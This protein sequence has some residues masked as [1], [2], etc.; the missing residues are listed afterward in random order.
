MIV[1]NR[2]VF[3]SRSILKTVAAAI[4]G[5]LSCSLVS[6]HPSWGIVVSSNGIVYF[7]DL[8]TI[9]RID[10][11]GKLSVVRAGVSGRHTHE[12]AIDEQDDIYGPDL[13][14]EPAT[15]KWITAIWKMTPDGKF[16]YLQPPSNQAPPGMSIWLDRGGNM[17][18]VD[19]NNHTKTKTVLLKRTPK[20]V[21]STLAGGVYGHMDGKG[22]AAKLSTVG[23]MVFGADGNLYLSDGEYV[24]RV[25]MD[26]AVTTIAKD[27]LSRTAED[28][29]ALFG[30]SYGSL[31]GL[32]TEPGGNVYVADAGNR[33]LLKISRDG[34][35]T[36][37]YRCDPPFF[38]NGVFATSAG[39]VYV[40]EF[41]FVPPGTWGGPR[42]RKIAADGTMSLLVS[43]TTIENRPPASAPVTLLTGP[44]SQSSYRVAILLIV[45]TAGLIAIL[46]TWANL[47][48]RRRT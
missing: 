21:I 7:S 20:G 31:A 28:K 23:A 16:E 11:N 22:P 29:P 44:T 46:L 26:G 33:R 3:F 39:E 13:S 48:K 24:R 9:W 45:L 30:G 14:Y 5:T 41:S 12:L 8:E 37:V 10:R 15:Q 27:L 43:D 2:G 19:Q 40:L 47:K 6:A 25:S 17:Y 36:V 42:V 4:L 38:P 34:K 1:R 32:S 35:V 18:S